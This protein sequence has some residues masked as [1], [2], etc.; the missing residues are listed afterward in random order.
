M[1][2]WI[3]KEAYKNASLLTSL[4]RMGTPFKAVIALII[5]VIIYSALP[6]WLRW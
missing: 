5:T 4:I 6:W 2:R 3:L 1:K